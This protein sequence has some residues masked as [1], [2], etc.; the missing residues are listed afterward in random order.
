MLLEG[1]GSELENCLHFYYRVLAKIRVE[2]INDLWACNQDDRNNKQRNSNALPN[3]FKVVRV[4]LLAHENQP[5]GNLGSR[6][7]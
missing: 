2:Q 4:F 1:S 6:A 3:L 5:R 7:H